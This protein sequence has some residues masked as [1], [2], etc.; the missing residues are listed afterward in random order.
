MLMPVTLLNTERI[1]LFST[2]S[3]WW[4]ALLGFALPV[5]FAAMYATESGD[6]LSLTVPATQDGYR[7]GMAVLMVLGVVAV[8]GEYRF[9]TMRTAFQAVPRRWAVLVAKTAVVAA[10]SG[11]VGEATAFASWGV[12]CLIRPDVDLTLNTPAE[13]RSVA[14]VGLVYLFASVIAVAVGVL[15]RQ[16]AGAI[17]ILFIYTLLAESLIAAVPGA[18]PAI[19]HWM[20]FYASRVF[21]EAGLGFDAAGSAP[22]GPWGGLLYFG[23]VALA[24]LGVALVVV[25]RRDA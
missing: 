23:G 18:G 14:G 12:A 10:V 13:W 2:R 15:V 25:E 3:P 11:A 24:L 21:L 22:Y 1:K 5:C 4:C 20:P 19:V 7:F 6:F 17:T 8:T 16:T 9:G